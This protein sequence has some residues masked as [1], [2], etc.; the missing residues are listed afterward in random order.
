MTLLWQQKQN[1]TKQ[2]HKQKNKKKQ[3]V[4]NNTSL[5]TLLQFYCFIDPSTTCF[6]YELLPFDNNIDWYKI[7]EQSELWNL[8]ALNFWNFRN[9]QHCS[10]FEDVPLI[11]ANWLTRVITLLSNH[12]VQRQPSKLPKLVIHCYNC[13]FDQ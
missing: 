3:W 5:A 8:S 10:K 13:L 1:K 11:W 2:R 9:P 6:S 12:T 7:N 4:I